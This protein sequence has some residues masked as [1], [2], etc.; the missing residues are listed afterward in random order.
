MID[1]GYCTKI[2]YE[3]NFTNNEAINDI[4][5]ILKIADPHLKI[6]RKYVEEN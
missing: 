5:Y 6:E 1:D 3:I 4:Q 2:L